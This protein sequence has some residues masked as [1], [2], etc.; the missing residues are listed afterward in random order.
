MTMRRNNAFQ[1]AT[2]ATAQSLLGPNETYLDGTNMIYTHEQAAPEFVWLDWVRMK[3]LRDAAPAQL[4]PLIRRIDA[5]RPKLMLLNYRTAALPPAL[6]LYARSQ[7]APLW[8]N[9]LYYAP[10]IAP[11]GFELH[12][13]GTYLADRPA[14]I[15][16]IDIAAGA[17]LPLHRG[18]HTMRASHPIR[19]RLLAPPG[20]P[21]DARFA[22]GGELLRNG[23]D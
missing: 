5:G 1:R 22:A 8:G 17:R 19:L 3:A 9:I 2:F 7:F 11:P 14:R 20:T 23:F 16:D 13:D 12:F 15:D 10:I 4:M 6:Q 21:F 18:W